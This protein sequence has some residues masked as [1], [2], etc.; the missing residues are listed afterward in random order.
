MAKGYALKNDSGQ[1][2]DGN[3]N[4]LLSVNF[5]PYAFHARDATSGKNYVAGGYD[6]PAADADLTQASLTVVVGDADAA[7]GAHAFIVSGGNGSTDGS[8]LVLTVSGTSITDA[9]VRTA[10]D[11]EV[12]EATAEVSPLDTYFETTKKWIGLVTYTLSSTA[13]T[14][15]SYTFNYGLAKYDDLGNRNFTVVGFEATGLANQNDSGFNVGLIHHKSTGWT[16]SAA[17][18]VPGT[19]FITDMNSVYVTEKNLVDGKPFA[20]KLSPLSQAIVGNNGEGIII[21]TDTAS[22]NSVSYMNIRVDVMITS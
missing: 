7:E 19:G 2:L 4:I 6:A 13:G 16:Y 18:F 3:G 10:A 1:V 8:D 20:F 22:S 5:I 17:A 21:Q 15:F 14:A 12:I 9:G 11:S